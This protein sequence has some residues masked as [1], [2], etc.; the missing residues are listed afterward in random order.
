MTA[1]PGPWRSEGVDLVRAVSGG[2][3]FGVPLLYTMEVWWIGSHTTPPQMAV[4]LGLLVLPIFALNRAAGFRTSSDSRTVDAV[5]DTIEAIAVG[6][7]VTALVLALL[8]EIDADSSAEL[9]L[10]KT[11]YESVPFCLGIGFARHLLLGSRSISADD[12]DDGRTG[13]RRRWSRDGD[14]EIGVLADLGA[15]AV[16]ATFVA[17]SIAPTDEVPMIAVAMTPAR[18]MLVVAASLI[19]SYGIVFVAGFAGQESRRTKRGPLQ[20]PLVETAVCYLL[21]LV[22]SFVLLWAFQRGVEPGSDLLARMVVLG[23]PAAIGGAAGRL[24]I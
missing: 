7:V 4:L 9:A 15:S 13:G 23:F 5:A 3:L 18:L 21:G 6:L 1:R 11:L 22:V 12:H 24:A 14:R 2:L 19:A 20:R 16:G 8:R 10:G 17:L